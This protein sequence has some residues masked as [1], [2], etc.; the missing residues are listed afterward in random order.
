MKRREGFLERVEDYII[1][2]K[3]LE[4][5]NRVLVGFSGGAD[6]TSLLLALWHLRSRLGINLLAA[7][8][9]YN[10][11]AEENIVEE[12]F[13]KD[14]CFSRNI[15]LLVNEYK[16]GKENLNENNLREYRQRW[17][18]SLVDL[19]NI[20]KIALGHNRGDQAETML[21]RLVRGSM[22]TGLGGIKPRS[23]RIIHPLLPLSR[24]EICDY[25]TQEGITWCEDSSNQESHFVRNKIRNIGLRW[26]KENL[27]PRVEERL[28]ETSEFLREADEIL[29]SHALLR[30]HTKIIKHKD[31]DE[32]RLDIKEL[33]KLKRVSRFYIYRYLY[34]KI[35]GYVQDFYQS[36][37]Q[38]I[39]D[40]L[41]RPGNRTIQLPHQIEL[42]KEYDDLV[43][44]R[45][46]KAP[47]DYQPDP[48]REIASL[49]NRFSYSEWRISMKRL[50]LLPHK[51]DPYWD[52]K[53]IYLDYDQVIWPLTIRHR[54]AGDRFIPFGMNNFKKLKD[55]F[56]DCKVPPR[57]REQ[58]LVFTDAEKII[59]IGGLRLDQRVAIN[60]NTSNILMIKIEKIR[61]RKARPAER[62]QKRD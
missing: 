47:K 55:Y 36:N 21:F 60:E 9:N 30:L 2:H 3:L 29:R 20:D 54:L 10:L 1:E 23:G 34:G 6:S 14:F 8:I 27:N 42:L 62:R 33:L 32:Y 18:L 61:R 49:R 50:K 58:A 35:N 13:I 52:K 57:D 37:F 26:I 11:R 46:G 25:L 4:K 45:A 22:L 38:E 17:F 31:E 53:T 19:Y 59:W 15:A 28:S 12:Q 51:R 16:P 48:A 41:Q 44:Y 56:I 39:E 24:T 40:S 43:F 5:K 7:H